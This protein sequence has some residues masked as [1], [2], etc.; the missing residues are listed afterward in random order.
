MT[1]K[2]KHNKSLYKPK[3]NYLLC[4]RQMQD[5]QYGVKLQQKRCELDNMK[6]KFSQ[7]DDVRETVVFLRTKH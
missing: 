6:R 3:N 4:P 5:E 7:H 2:K 1:V